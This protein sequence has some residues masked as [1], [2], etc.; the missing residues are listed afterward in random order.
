MKRCKS[1]FLLL[2]LSFAILAMSVPAGAGEPYKIGYITDLSGPLRDAYS[3]VMEGFRLYVKALNDR[4]GINGHPIDMLIRNDQ[5]DATR[6][7]SFAMELITGEKINSIWGMSLTRTHKAVY[8]QAKRYKTPAV[9]CFSGIKAVLPPSPL[10]YAYS[11]GFVFEA[12]GDVSGKLAAELLKGKGK[13][14]VNSIEAPGGYAAVNYA[15]R[16]AQAGG[17]ST[18]QVLFSPRTTEFGPSAQKIVAMKPDIIVLHNPPAHALGMIR[19][20]RGIGYKGIVLVAALGMD[21]HTFAGAIESSGFTEKTYVFSRWAFANSEGKELD[22]L[23]AAAKKYGIPS[24]LNIGNVSG[25]TMGVLAE[26]SLK[27]GGWPLSGEKLNSILQNITVDTGALMGGPIKFTPE[28]HYG[29][30]WYRLFK[31]DGKT[32]TFKVASGWKEQTSKLAPLK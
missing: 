11:V 3:P 25:W 19:S 21:E 10:D 28:D 30:T 29:T 17:L 6:A 14:V 8:Q 23:R 16:S 1:I 20:L 7:S 26:A 9:S 27:K 32:K 22:Q 13:M 5:L 24:K 31:Y 18:D 4:G 15:E 2:F 12:G